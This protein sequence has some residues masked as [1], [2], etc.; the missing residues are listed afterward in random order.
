MDD[1]LSRVPAEYRELVR[2][3]FRELSRQ[4]D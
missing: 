3:Y 4:E 2:K 1:A